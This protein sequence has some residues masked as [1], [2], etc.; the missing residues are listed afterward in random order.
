M[1]KEKLTD[2]FVATVKA[3][4]Q[5]DYFDTL[6][7]GLALRVSPTRKTWSL[8]YTRPGSRQRVRVTLG[9]YSEEFGVGKARKRAREMKAD[10]ADGK[11]PK[12]VKEAAAAAAASALTMSELVEDYIARRVVGLRSADEVT[13]RLR[14]NILDPVHG[15]GAV[16]VPNLHRRDIVKAL[17]AVEDRG[18][19]T[20]ASRCFEDVRAVVRWAVGRGVIDRDVT[21]GMKAPQRNNVRD[22]VLNA[23]EIKNVFEALPTAGMRDGVEDVVRLLFETA[24]RVSEIAAIHVRELDFVGDMICLPPDRVKNGLAHEVP[25]TGT[26]KAILKR[27]AEGKK[28]YLFPVGEDGCLRGDVVA[29][30]LA[31]AQKGTE[32]G[33]GRRQRDATMPVAGWTAH[34]VRRTWATLASKLG[35]PPHVIA[36]SLNHQSVNSSVTFAHYVRNDF[37]PERREAHKLVS[38][39]IAGIVGQGAKVLPLK[40]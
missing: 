38:A 36:A 12:T 14:R 37:M 10:V 30:E 16:L 33:K 15:L 18:A 25:M 27:L 40:A 31:K 21:F 29:N 5:T 1:P 4:A 32:A 35:V 9:E 24:C 20:E 8:M 6:E 3:E 26:A 34:D 17:D 11:D 22:R 28:G 2:R 19:K 13:R 23:A 39:H 7:P